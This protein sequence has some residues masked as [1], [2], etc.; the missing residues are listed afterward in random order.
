MA[1]GYSVDK[2]VAAGRFKRGEPPRVL[3]VSGPN[4]FGV[5]RLPIVLASAGF[6]VSVLAHPKS[7]VACSG[8]LRALVPGSFCPKENLELFRRHVSAGAQY[9]WV[10]FADDPTMMEAVRRS[11]E[12]WLVPWFPASSR[13]GDPDVLIH[14]TLF[15]EKAAAAGLPVPPY[16][17]VVSSVELCAAAAELGFP[18]IVK[19]ALGFAGN[20]IFSANTMAELRGRSLPDGEWCVQRQVTGRSGGT[21]LLLWNNRPVW[22]Q[23]SLRTKVWP[24]PFGPSCRR[25]SIHLPEMPEILDRLASALDFYGLCEVEW[26]LPDC[27]GPPLLIEF[28]PR[29]ASYLYTTTAMGGDLPVALRSLFAGKEFNSSSTGHNGS[30]VALFPEDAI[31]AAK[32][33]DISRLWAW[34]SGR[35]QSGFAKEQ[36][37]LRRYRWLAFKAVLRSALAKLQ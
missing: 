12:E 13:E 28:N 32:Q 21:A 36:R 11:R 10:I 22:W 35:V 15:I 31:Q 27:G 9:D 37:L 16:C 18:V 30:E 25:T 23:N 7:F 26:I 4:W 2:T 19:P 1:S 29:P 34:C 6:E 8:F 33:M 3:C 20:G 14:K 17:S 24:E 5:S